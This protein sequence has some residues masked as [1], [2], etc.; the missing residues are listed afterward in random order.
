MDKLFV[1]D[2]QSQLTNLPSGIH[3]LRIKF[4]I[5]F[6]EGLYLSV[7][8][9]ARVWSECL[10]HCAQTLDTQCKQ[11]GL[12]WLRLRVWF[13]KKGHE[14]NNVKYNQCSEHKIINKYLKFL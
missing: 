9:A 5:S 2:T 10:G 12:V 8:H 4:P 1:C 7:G 11:L 3:W 13:R 6:Q 14:V